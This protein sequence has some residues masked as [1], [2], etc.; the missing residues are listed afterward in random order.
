MVQVNWTRDAIN[1]LKD[2]VDYISRDSQ[3]YAEITAQRIVFK[4]D[5]LV[6]FPRSGRKVPEMSRDDIRE[7]IEGRYRIIYRV[8]SDNRVDILTVHHSSRLLENNPILKK[9]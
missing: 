5:L 8:V 3:R 4:A 9:L 2:I 1:D 6:T 7:M